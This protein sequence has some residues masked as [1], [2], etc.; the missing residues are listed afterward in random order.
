[1]NALIPSAGG[2]RFLYQSCPLCNASDTTEVVRADC[3][4]HSLYNAA[5]LPIITW[6]NCKT[7]GHVFTN[8]FYTDTALSAI[9]SKTHE[10]QLVGHDYE[11]QRYVSARIIEQV[12]PYQA[13][14]VWLDVGFGNGALLMT[15]LEYG[16]QPEGIDLRKDNVKRMKAAG[17]NA[18]A[19]PI[20]EIAGA[21]RFDV[22]SFM[23][24][25]EHIPFPK[26]ALSAARRLLKPDGA[27]VLSMPN[28]DSPIWR[29]LDANKQNPYWGELEHYHN[30]GKKRLY[31]LLAEMQFTPIKYG[32]STRY[33]ACMEVIAIKSNTPI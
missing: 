2:D 20:Q 6:L 29:L 14:G 5:I 23:D 4:R 31:E 1:M 13:S 24:V 16:F 18:Y 9:F 26:E 19:V 25:L 3:S 7:C 28:M 8:G 32:I 17:I 21:D 10:G 12:L 33:R 15:A 30:F 27:L 11:N 22:M